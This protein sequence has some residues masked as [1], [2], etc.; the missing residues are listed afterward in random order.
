MFYVLI[1]RLEAFPVL[2]IGYKTFNSGCS[3]SF[4]EYKATSQFT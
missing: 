2:Y 4:S 3:E 1:N